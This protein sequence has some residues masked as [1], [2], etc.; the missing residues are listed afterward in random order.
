MLAH[1][2]HFCVPFRWLRKGQFLFHLTY[3]IRIA[4]SPSRLGM[5]KFFSSDKRSRCFCY[6]G[7]RLSILKRELICQCFSLWKIVSLRHRETDEMVRK[8]ISSS[9]QFFPGKKTP[10]DL[11]IRT[12]IET[13]NKK[14][15]QF[16]LSSNGSTMMHFFKALVFDC[17]TKRRSDCVRK[18][19]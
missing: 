18:C 19:S 1:W 8:R 16:A 11:F 17:L 12:L 3:G 5:R 2:A 15:T 7:A 4:S 13:Q 6:T 10:F 9:Q 14:S